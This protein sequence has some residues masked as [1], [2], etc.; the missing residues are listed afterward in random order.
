MLCKANIQDISALAKVKAGFGQADILARF[1]W[2]TT[3]DVTWY[4]GWVAHKPRG[5]ALIQWQGKPTAPTY[6]DLFDLYV[7]PGWRGHGIGTQILGACEQIVHD[8]GHKQLGLAVNP[9]LN[10]RAYLLYQN[11][12]YVAISQDKYLDGVYDGVEDWVIDLEKN[13]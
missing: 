13:L 1:E 2:L 9:D 11:L 12:G 6:P 4:V 3:V 5:W 7:Y 10:P 8:A